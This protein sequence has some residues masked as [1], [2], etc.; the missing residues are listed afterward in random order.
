MEKRWKEDKVRGRQEREK[1]EDRGKRSV[2]PNRVQ[3]CVQ[4]KHSPLS[5]A[6]TIAY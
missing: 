3:I 4:T 6:S 2:L 5:S 1:R